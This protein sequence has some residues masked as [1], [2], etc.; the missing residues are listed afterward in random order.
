V[1]IDVGTTIVDN[2]QGTAMQRFCVR[3]FRKFAS[4]H[5]PMVKPL[6]GAVASSRASLLVHLTPLDRQISYRV[7]VVDRSQVLFI[8]RIC[9]ILLHSDTKPAY[10]TNICQSS[11]FLMY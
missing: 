7:Q 3:N 1:H 9:H 5:M 11:H 6:I 2:L 8:K 4:I 10:D